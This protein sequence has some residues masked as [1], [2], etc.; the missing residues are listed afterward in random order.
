MRETP[1]AQQHQKE[2]LITQ[3][4]RRAYFCVLKWRVG[5][6]S[7]PNVGTEFRQIHE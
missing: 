4:S 7:P 5:K 2:T 6:Q 1:T 3:A